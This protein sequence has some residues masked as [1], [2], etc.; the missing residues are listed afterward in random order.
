MVSYHYR[1]WGDRMVLENKKANEM[2]PPL[3]SGSLGVREIDCLLAILLPVS[4][5]HVKIPDIELAPR[6]R[7]SEREHT[8]HLHKYRQFC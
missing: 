5:T 6:A 8:Q 3:Y 7:P 4:T 1:R 2:K